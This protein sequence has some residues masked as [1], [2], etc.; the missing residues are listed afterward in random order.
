VQPR[1]NLIDR[2][3]EDEILPFC[4]EEGL[5]IV[6][7]SPL[8]GGFLT[9]KYSS[10]QDPPVDSRFG[11]RGKYLKAPYW[12]AA[13]FD[14]V[15]SLKKVAEKHGKTPAQ[16]ALAWLIDNPLVT[17]PII[18]ATSVSQLNETIEAADMSLSDD[19]RQACDNMHGVG[20]H[21]LKPLAPP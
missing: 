10:D 13:N 1:Y 3:I 11:R 7:Y 6:S 5:G 8:A 17:A 12:H 16:L 21:H 15:D 2:G 14:L 4:A 19:E 20:P 9:G 18:G